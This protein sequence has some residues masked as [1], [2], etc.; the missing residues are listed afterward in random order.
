MLSGGEMPR[1]PGFVTVVIDPAFGTLRPE[2]TGHCRPLCAH[3]GHN[4][5]IVSLKCQLMHSSHYGS[6]FQGVLDTDPRVSYDRHRP[7]TSCH[8]PEP[9]T[10][11]ADPRACGSGSLSPAFFSLSQ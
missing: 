8:R 10:P 7:D 4:G 9:D 2:R 3:S 11:I 5:T 1:D 6:A